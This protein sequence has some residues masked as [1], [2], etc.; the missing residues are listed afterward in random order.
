[1]NHLFIYTEKQSPR[2][3]YIFDFLFTEIL[4]LTYELTHEKEK[5]R[6]Y[7]GPKFSYAKNPVGDE[8]F[9]EA[10]QLLFETALLLQPIDFCDYENMT[11][12]Y[13][14]SKRSRMPFDPFASA[15]LMVTCY[16]EY[17]LHK[18]DKYDRYRAS[19]SLNYK[20]GFLD[21]PMVDIYALGLKKILAEHFP[22]LEFRER[23]FKYVATFDID[24][25][26]SYLEKGLTTNLGGFARSFVLSDFKDI[27][28]RY[29]VLFRGEPDPFDTYDYIFNTCAGNGIETKFFF[30]LGDKS[31][32]DKNIAYENEKFR[33]LIKDIAAKTEV[34]IHL[35]FGSHVSNGVMLQEMKRL[36]EITGAAPT[37]N[38]FHY[39]RFTLPSSYMR[40]QKIGIKED[41][42]MAYATRIGFRSGTCTPYY[43]FNLLNNEVSGLKVYPFAF[44][45][46]TLSHYRR[47]TPEESIDRI[48]QVLKAVKEVG[49]LCIGLWHNSSFTEEG[50]WKGWRQVFE[51]IS[52]DAAKLMKEEE[53]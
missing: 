46:T 25:A 36:E 31:R 17:L 50:E 38:R 24:M 30:L 7:Q 52:S 9:F 5:I 13:F 40:L 48:R 45:D 19:Q 43:F 1:M 20:A 12:F 49:G 4:G 2:V 14:V 16:N 18:K 41:Y 33:D 21:K 34:G 8:L 47:F 15:F 3:K 10:A 37:I 51:T 26:Y 35:S 42:S 29:G 27:R 44:M 23:K 28:T 6:N 11:G 39:L 22:E 53:E 32:L